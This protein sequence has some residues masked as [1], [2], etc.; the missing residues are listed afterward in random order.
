MLIHVIDI[1]L[2]GRLI[3]TSDVFD[4]LRGSGRRGGVGDGADFRRY[5]VRM[6]S[7]RAWRGRP[8]R[9]SATSEVALSSKSDEI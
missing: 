6:N 3:G 9:S 7:G 5:E 8:A 1:D 4:R 2:I